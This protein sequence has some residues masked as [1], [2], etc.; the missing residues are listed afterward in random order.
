MLRT[1]RG[2][3][4]KPLIFDTVS[5]IRNYDTG[6]ANSISPSFMTPPFAV[7]FYLWPAASMTSCRAR[8]LWSGVRRNIVSVFF[9]DT[10]KPAAPK[11]VTMTVIIFASTSV[12]F[13]TIPASSAYSMPHTALRTHADGSCYSVPTTPSSLI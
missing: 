5:P 12:N 6:V 7:C 8:V 4:N 10:V 1:W 2:V 9:S 13:E 3:A 11:T